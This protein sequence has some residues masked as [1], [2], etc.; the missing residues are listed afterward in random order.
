M[1]RNIIILLLI[2]LF[3]LTGCTKSA[4]I[5]GKKIALD[6]KY[7]DGIISYLYP[8]TFEEIESDEGYGTF[9]ERKNEYHYDEPNEKTFIIRVEEYNITKSFKDLEE[10]MEKVETND[11]NR[12]LKKEKVKAKNTELRKYS[13]VTNS[14]YGNDTTYHLYYGKFYATGIYKYIKIYFIN[15]KGREDFEKEFISNVII[16]P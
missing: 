6:Q 5:N 9:Y 1:K 2:S 7:N 4:V 16:K 11:S 10:D 12:Y 3:L 13:Y 8:K 14:E 15:T